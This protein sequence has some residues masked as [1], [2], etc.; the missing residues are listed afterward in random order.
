MI[1]A[2]LSIPKA[3]YRQFS[4]SARMTGVTLSDKEPDPVDCT[5]YRVLAAA[6][7]ARNFYHL[8]RQFQ[9]LIDK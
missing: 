4:L 6:D 5:R 9:H 8:G 7:S 3:T 2:Y 1:Q